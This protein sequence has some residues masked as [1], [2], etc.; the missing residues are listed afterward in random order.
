MGAAPPDLFRR[1]A[2][3]LV[4]WGPYGERLSTMLASPESADL[5]QRLW[6][7]DGT[8]WRDDARSASEIEHR[9]GW[10]DLPDSM[11]LEV[12]RLVALRHE[13]RAAG[14]NRAVLLG[15][16]GSAIAAEVFAGCCGAQADGL[17]LTV[18]DTTDPDEVRQALAEHDL[19]RT[20]LVV[21]SK[22]GTTVEPLALVE[23]FKAAMLAGPVGAAWPRHLVAITDAGSRLE[24]L[25]RREGY[26]ACY[27]NPPDVAGRYAPLSLFGLVPAA[28]LGVDL[29]RLLG[30]AKAM[31]AACAPYRPP[32]ENPGLVLGTALGA[33]ARWPGEHRNKL[34]LLASPGLL[35]MAAWIEQLIAESTGK[36][37]TGILPLMGARLEQIPRLSEDRFYVY[38]RLSADADPAQD[39]LV[40][41]LA[42]RDQPVVTL[43]LADLH[44]LGGEF[45]R[46][47]Y[48]TAVAGKLLGV[49][50]FDQ[51]DVDSAKRRAQGAL[52]RYG[53]NGAFSEEPP[54]LEDERLMVH[55]PP[56]GGEQTV[57]DYLRAFL[58]QA[59]PGQYVALLA[60]LPRTAEFVAGLAALRHEMAARTGVPTTLGFGPRYLHSTGQ[61]HKGGPNT[62]LFVV[63]TADRPEELP[64]PGRTY[65]LAAL[66]MAQALGDCES[67]KA[68]GRRVVRIHL[69]ASPEAG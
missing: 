13:V 60:Y 38:L 23:L 5:C 64:I 25:A 45:V 18:L 26:R 43:E 54:V 50:P 68:R 58:A 11:R 8:L 39:A 53:L 27:L 65:G 19:A 55:G 49:N 35:P 2:G 31:L 21:A 46:W 16:G 36:Q 32:R 30:S 15:M 4:H 1:Q 17:A 67:L 22:S 66:Q 48:A 51:P 61:Y 9:L 20:L 37:R 59:A 52:A 40:A 3:M 6:G 33:L 34:T 62:G 41:E 42:A 7:R 63:I 10:L 29:D 14:L 56:L 44:D 57:A 47:E 69:R 12:T 28:L 24:A